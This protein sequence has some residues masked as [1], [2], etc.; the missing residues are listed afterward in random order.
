MIGIGQ[1]NQRFAQALQDEPLRQRLI[2]E[3]ARKSKACG[4]A[5]ALQAAIALV[6]FLLPGP[7]NAHFVFLGVGLCFLILCFRLRR[8]LK[9]LQ[10]AEP[11]PAGQSAAT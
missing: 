4:W 8:D 9:L 2:A 3:Y 6:L 11:R 7:Q 10:R 5:A 1:E